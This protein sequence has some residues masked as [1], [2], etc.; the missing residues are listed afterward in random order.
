MILTKCRARL[1]LSIEE[2]QD[3][4]AYA[5]IQKIIIAAFNFGIASIIE[6]LRNR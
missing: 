2:N 1:A 5:I 3:Q 4:P 6:R